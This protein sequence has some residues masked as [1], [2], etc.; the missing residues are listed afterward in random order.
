MRS[1]GG[2]RRGRPVTLTPEEKLGRERERW[3][4]R[5]ARK[6]KR[7]ADRSFVQSTPQGYF[8]Q[9]WVFHYFDLVEALVDVGLLDANDAEIPSRVDSAVD[10]YFCEAASLRFGSGYRSRKLKCGEPRIIRVRMTPQLAHK[11]AACEQ[12]VSLYR[13]QL[14]LTTL[15]ALAELRAQIMELRLSGR[16]DEL[17]AAEAKIKK[18]EGEL[19]MG[20]WSNGPVEPITDR[21]RL[22]RI[23]ERCLYGFY[24]T[25]VFDPPVFPCTCP[26]A[27]PNCDCDERFRPKQVAPV[28]PPKNTVP[29][30]PLVKRCL[31]S[32]GMPK[33]WK[34]EKPRNETDPNIRQQEGVATE[35]MKGRWAGGAGN[36][37]AFHPEPN[38]FEN[39][40]HED[41]PQKRDRQATANEGERALQKQF[42]DPK[43]TS[44]SWRNPND[45]APDKEPE[46]L[47]RIGTR[48]VEE[49]EIEP[50]KPHKGD[51][52]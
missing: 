52:C 48:I 27:L 43:G 11:L 23:A 42:D 31:Y 30:R 34:S 26:L 41:S 19:V 14:D 1:S 18:L 28:R 13:S 35:G 44:K 16:I 24:S 38:S 21:K 12:G 10:Q 29:K 3:R 49:V 40:H 33:W 46:Q 50:Y 7:E 4:R 17:R 32:K 2:G 45:I 51:D 5:K 15:E 39:S 37:G 22:E 47:T 9:L 36:R 8:A 25:H 20:V 6:R